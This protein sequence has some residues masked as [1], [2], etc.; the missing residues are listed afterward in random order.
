[1]GLFRKKKHKLPSFPK[2]IKKT[3]KEYCVNVSLDKID[4]LKEKVLEQIEEAKERAGQG[5]LSDVQLAKEISERCLY[6]LD[7]YEDFSPRE[8]KLITGAVC[9]FA[10]SDDPISEEIFACGYD[11][12]AQVVNYVLEELKI[13]NMY[14]LIAD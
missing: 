6:L 3:F 12:D 13:D 4:R 10:I 5:R 2:T 14:I 9:Y 11:D 8:Q 1:M 7:H